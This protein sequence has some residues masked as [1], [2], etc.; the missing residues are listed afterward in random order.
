MKVHAIGGRESKHMVSVFQNFAQLM[1]PSPGAQKELY[2]E[3]TSSKIRRYAILMGEKTGT[4][5]DDV[6]VRKFQHI[7]DDLVDL[8]S[9][10]TTNRSS[11]FP[12]L[13]TTILTLA[14]VPLELYRMAREDLSYFSYMP[15]N[16]TIYTSFGFSTKI[17]QMEFGDSI[18]QMLIHE[19]CHHLWGKLGGKYSNEKTYRYWAEGFATYGEIFFFA[20]L[21]SKD[22]AMLPPP[23]EFYRRGMDSIAAV[24]QCHGDEAF[25]RVPKEWKTFQEELTPSPTVGGGDS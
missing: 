2:L 11:F 12:T 15:D 10:K 25:L 14:K 16:G 7:M 8:V 4:T 22:Y 18:D 19:L 3:L 21:Y 1:L 9:P 20:D 5:L 6:R 23:N 24:I 13:D 17:R